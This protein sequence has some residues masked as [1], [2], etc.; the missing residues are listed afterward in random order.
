MTARATEIL[1]DIT[2]TLR[3]S[4]LFETV[5]LGEDA[6]SAAIPR[7]GVL[8]D[9]FEVFPCDDGGAQWW[10]RLS[11]RLCLRVRSND[12]STAVSRLMDLAV[13]ATEALME[14]PYR[15]QRCLDLPIGLATETGR[16]E[17]TPRLRRPD[18][19]GSVAVRCHFETEGSA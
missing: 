14:D 11:V 15:G 5:T 3:T 9:S 12:Y 13:A 2:G 10:A 1:Q 7:A 8:L 17:I 19:E 16:F 18:M 6:G 4:G